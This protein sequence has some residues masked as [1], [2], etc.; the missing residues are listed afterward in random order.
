M[1]SVPKGT[2]Y[3]LGLRPSLLVLT[4]HPLF[5]GHVANMTTFF[6]MPRELRDATYWQMDKPTLANFARSA[7]QPAREATPVLEQ[8]FSE[9]KARYHVEHDS[10]LQNVRDLFDDSDGTSKISETLEDTYRRRAEAID[11]DTTFL[12]GVHSLWGLNSKE[13]SLLLGILA[14]SAVRV[15]EHSFG[16]FKQEL[17]SFKPNITESENI[18][19]SHWEDRRANL[20]SI[21]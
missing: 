5:L 6:S 13:R 19:L 11:R 20:S 16:I 21:L 17:N 7:R 18:Y 12:I 2:V 14:P 8:K 9:D 4:F 3:A 1:R 10:Y 15:S